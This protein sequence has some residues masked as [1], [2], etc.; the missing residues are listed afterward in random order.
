MNLGDLQETIAQRM[1]NRQDLEGPIKTEFKLVQRSILEGAEFKPWFALG[2]FAS[3]PLTVDD[4]RL[5][6]PADFLREAEEGALYYIGDNAEHAL[7]KRDLDELRRAFKGASKGPPEFY[8][9]AG[10]YFRI[11]PWPDKLYRMRLM[12]YRSQPLCEEP[13]DTNAWLTYAFDVCVAEVGL[14]MGSYNVDDKKL[15]EFAQER[16][17][18]WRRLMVEHEARDHTNREYQKGSIG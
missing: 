6:V 14:K 5:P 13:S 18:A 7:A 11:F 4:N 2:E 8:A 16:S 15:K 1:G 17:T 10:D 12:Y 9:L 3:A